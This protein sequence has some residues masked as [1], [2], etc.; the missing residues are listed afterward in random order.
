MIDEISRYTQIFLGTRSEL[1]RKLFV[2]SENMAKLYERFFGYR[3]LTDYVMLRC[4]SYEISKI[5]AHFYCYFKHRSLACCDI[6]MNTGFCKCSRIISFVLEDNTASVES[7]TL[8]GTFKRSV[9]VYIIFGIG[10]LCLLHKVDYSVELVVKL[11]I[12]R[13]NKKV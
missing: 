4:I 8:I 10:V 2:F 1:I 6:V 5:I 11:L 9:R 13:V 3:M 12:V 7:P